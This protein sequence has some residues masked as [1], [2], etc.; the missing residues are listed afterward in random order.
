MKG[1]TKGTTFNY[2][3]NSYDFQEGMLV[4]IAPGQVT[5]FPEP[6]EELDDTG[7]TIVFHPDLIRRSSLGK[8]IK[9]HTFFSYEV[10]EA[11]HLSEKEKEFLIQ[12]VEKIEL[13]LEQNIDKYSQ[14][15]I[16][17]NLETILKYSDRYYDR[18]FYTRANLNKDYVAKFELFLSDYFASEELTDKGIPSIKR[19]GEALNMSG[20]YLSDLLK[21]ETGR[22]AKDHI[23]SYIIEQAK[24]ELLGSKQPISRIAFNLGFE[25][26]QHFS[27][28]FKSKS[29]F[30]PSEY[31][32]SN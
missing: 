26:P 5:S 31:R 18:Q 20:S 12:L 25:Y 30:S 32:N 14:E 17:H 16:I 7:W 11:L 10:T 29:G 28:L 13:E 27:K 15:L 24:T 22:S 8:T 9:D 23:H 6:I 19:C 2:G 21:I 3:R 4:F 1:K